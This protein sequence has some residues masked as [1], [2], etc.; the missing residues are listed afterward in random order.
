MEKTRKGHDQ[1]DE[2]PSKADDQAVPFFLLLPGLEVKQVH[3]C[4]DGG[5]GGEQANEDRAADGDGNVLKELTGLLSNKD[6][7]QEH[8]DCGQSGGQHSTVD[9]P[10]PIIDRIEGVFPHLA[11]PV[12]VLQ[13]HDGTVHEHAHCEADA[14]ETDYV[15]VPVEEPEKDK[16]P[17]GGHGDGHGRGEGGP[18]ASEK[19][20]Q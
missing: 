9:F 3:C 18:E 10:G 4:G 11:V 7:W 13:H 16:G 12:D 14:G 8:G 17:Y 5:H 15:Q 19:Q 2:A 6:D 20:Q 1:V